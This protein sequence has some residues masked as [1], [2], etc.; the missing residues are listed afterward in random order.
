MGH[1]PTVVMVTAY[2]QYAIEAFEAGA[3]DY[4]LKTVGQERLAQAVER[5]QRTVARN[6]VYTGTVHL[7]EIKNKIVYIDQFVTSNIMNLLSPDVA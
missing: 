7:P 3:S 4:L 1:L 5:V 2:D 6:L